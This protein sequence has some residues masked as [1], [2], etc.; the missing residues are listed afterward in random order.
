LG[1]HGAGP[2]FV[3][4]CFRFWCFFHSLTVKEQPTDGQTDYCGYG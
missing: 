2:N 4:G 1:V 3:F